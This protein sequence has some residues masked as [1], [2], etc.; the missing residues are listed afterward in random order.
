LIHATN[1]RANATQND[2]THKLGERVQVTTAF[3]FNYL[4]IIFIF[5]KLP[6]YTLAGFDLT[7]H[8]SS[9]LGIRRRRYHYVGH[10]AIRAVTP[11]FNFDPR[12]EL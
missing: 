12:G 4:L 1:T 5:K 8:S 9:L 10:A 6:P 2:V 11:V 3:L 7:T